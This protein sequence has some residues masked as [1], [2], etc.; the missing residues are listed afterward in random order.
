MFFLEVDKLETCQIGHLFTH[1][2]FDRTIKQ[3]EQEIEKQY[4]EEG[5]NGHDKS[6]SSQSANFKTSLDEKK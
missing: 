3:L 6:T 4:S 2:L 1:F 5:N